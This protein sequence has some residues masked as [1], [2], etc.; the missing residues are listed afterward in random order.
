[1]TPPTNS[2]LLPC[3]IAKSVA[4]QVLERAAIGIKKYGVN[5]TRNDLS[6]VD[7]LN[8]LQQEL[9]DAANYVERLKQDTRTS[10]SPATNLSELENAITDSSEVLKHYTNTDIPYEVPISLHC[11]R[12]L[13][14]AAKQH[15]SDAAKMAEK[16]A[17][18]EK[19][20]GVLYNI[21][22]QGNEMIPVWNRDEI[23]DIKQLA[24][25]KGYG[26]KKG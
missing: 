1:M 9:L 19:L 26:V 18:I 4:D 2:E 25:S 15:S 11:L 3:P 7:W 17:L 24:H 12:Q 14:P 5:L 21:N 20:V 6:H 22:L 23:T 16:D 10:P 8:H 13:V